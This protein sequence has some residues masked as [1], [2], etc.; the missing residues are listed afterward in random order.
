MI[1][2]MEEN[3]KIIGKQTVLVKDGK[4]KPEVFWSMGRIEAYAV[5]PDN[6]K[7]VYMVSYFCIQEIGRAHV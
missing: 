5:S 4:Y 2:N 6:T 3:N 1:L 7:I